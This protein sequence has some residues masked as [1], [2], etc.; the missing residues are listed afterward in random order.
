MLT[1]ASLTLVAAGRFVCG[2][3]AG[4]RLLSARPKRRR[5]A[6]RVRRLTAGVELMRA[7]GRVVSGGV[8]IKSSALTCCNDIRRVRS[9][10][11]GS[12]RSAVYRCIQWPSSSSS[13]AV[14]A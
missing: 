3:L 10:V 9:A 7:T 4:A 13:C 14:A 5:R 6:E 1:K 11:L 2:L 8:Q 12:R